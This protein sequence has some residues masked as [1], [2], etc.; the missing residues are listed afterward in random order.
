MISPTT[1]YALDDLKG[2]KLVHLNCRSL[3]SKLN[4]IGLL[5]GHVDILCL[6]E[7][8][9]YEAYSDV[10]LSISGMKLFR[11]DCSKGIN[12][13]VTKSRGGGLA[14]Y[15][16]NAIVADCSLI[17]DQCLTTPDI[18]LQ[19]IKLI[20]PVH[21]KRHVINLYQPPNG[22][23]DLY[24]DILEN[25]FLNLNLSEVWLMGDFNINYL[26]RSDNYT[27]KAI[28]FAR[29]YGLKPLITSAT[30]LGGFSSSCIDLMFTNADF[31]N[32]SGVLNDEI[33]DH[34]PI[35]ACV[36]KNEGKRRHI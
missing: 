31:I 1:V 8:W 15:V 13:G 33:S 21:K 35:F 22:N 14:C 20:Q 3:F 30:H 6:T 29:L 24:F 4:Q 27:K 18:E 26:K 32:T 10:V 28:D 11:W 19:V 5:F 23:I 16:K 36:K 9:L 34:F 25:L 17:L 2:F 12:N 7:T